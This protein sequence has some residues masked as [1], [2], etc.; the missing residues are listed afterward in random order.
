[1][2]ELLPSMKEYDLD[3]DD[4]TNF[5]FDRNDRCQMSD[6][7]Y[8]RAK[9]EGHAIAGVDHLRNGSDRVAFTQV[10]KSG[11]LGLCEKIRLP[12]IETTH[13]VHDVAFGQAPYGDLF[14]C[15]MLASLYDFKANARILDFGCSTGRVIRNLKSAYPF[16]DAYGC[17]P[18]VSSIEFIRVRV[19]NVSYFVSKEYPPIS[20]KAIPPL[21]M[22]FAISVWSHFSEPRALE[23]FAEMARLIR[24]GGKLIFSTHGLRSIF[25]FRH[26]K[27]VMPEQKAQERLRALINGHYHF[28]RYAASDLD[29]NW[30]MAFIPQSWVLNELARQWKV[31]KFSPGLAMANQDVYVLSRK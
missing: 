7:L 12:W 9:S 3:I 17:D 22:V 29:I 21:D 20:S 5:S 1:M 10:L 11:G 31:D 19:P 30:G 28:A 8:Q 23:W 25:H 2:S 27:K 14:F 18:R 16:I 4:E 24:S 13:D 6:L 15:D 26:V